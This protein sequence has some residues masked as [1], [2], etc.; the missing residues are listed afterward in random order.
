MKK[1]NY[2]IK[3]GANFDLI[4]S[5]LIHSL[6][7]HF[8]KKERKDFIQNYKKVIEQKKISNDYFSRNTFDWIEVLKDYK[9]KKFDYLE[10]G[11]LE[12]N[13]A[14]FVLKNFKNCYLKCVDCWEELDQEAD[15]YEGH[16]NEENFDQNLINYSGR[17]EKNKM[18][19]DLF[20]KKNSK[21]FDVIFV[22]GSHFADDVFKDFKNSWIILKKNG[23][24]IL[25]D[26]FWKGYKNL[27]QNP[28][29]AI[30]KFL[31]EINN[32]YKII[33]LTKFQLFLKK[34]S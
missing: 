10:I 20:F 9:D 28:A 7:S 1:L 21:F 13:S 14:I 25:D 32:E 30:N 22:D 26:Y 34:L 17:F 11:S 3:C 8:N 33:K 15:S 6:K 5:Y 12:G 18:L 24:L 31:K 4:K 29:F 19:S 23:T 2:L 27:Q 16:K